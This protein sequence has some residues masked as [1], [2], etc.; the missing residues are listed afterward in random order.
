MTQADF[1]KTV[2]DDLL[3]CHLTALIEIAGLNVPPPFKLHPVVAQ[4]KTSELSHV[5]DTY[6][7]FLRSVAS[8][9]LG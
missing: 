2:N 4:V 1:I 9:K 8:V 3:R 6:R 7:G 5:V